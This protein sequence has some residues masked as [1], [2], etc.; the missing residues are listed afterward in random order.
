MPF[1]RSY[2]EI[3]KPTSQPRGGETAGTIR[4]AVARRAALS[5]E[6]DRADEA[7]KAFFATMSDYYRTWRDDFTP[8]DYDAHRLRIARQ[9]AQLVRRLESRRNTAESVP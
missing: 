9:I 2:L 4:S 3:V 8:T 1:H 6:A 5:E 7:R